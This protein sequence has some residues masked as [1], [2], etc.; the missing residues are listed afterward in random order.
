MALPVRMTDPE[1]TT[2]PHHR[3]QEGSVH[4]VEVHTANGKKLRAL[5]QSADCLDCGYSITRQTD[6]VP[7]GPW[8]RCDARPE[9]RLARR[10]EPGR[11]WHGGG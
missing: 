11:P 5:R 7:F 2:C 1:P 10:H 4:A 9:R 3:R 6:P 8:E